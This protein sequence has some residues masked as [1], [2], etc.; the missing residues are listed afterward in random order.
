MILAG[1]W[2]AV[3][4]RHGANA[5]DSARPRPLARIGV[6][7]QHPAGLTNR[8]A[9]GVVSTRRRGYSPVMFFT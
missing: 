8:R 4:L 9:A 3:G 2:T 5:A 7:Q 6:N 1:S